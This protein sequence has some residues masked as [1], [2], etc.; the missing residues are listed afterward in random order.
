[1]SRLDILSLDKKTIK[2]FI[3]REKI[4]KINSIDTDTSQHKRCKRDGISKVDL[5]E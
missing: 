4:A 3:H 1:M 5:T 2:D